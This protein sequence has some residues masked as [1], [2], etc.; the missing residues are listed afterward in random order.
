MELMGAV[1]AFLS[2]DDGRLL[3]ADYAKRYCPKPL[4]FFTSFSSPMG[5]QEQDA[6]LPA[7]RDKPLLGRRSVMA[8]LFFKSKYHG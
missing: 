6:T 4:S 5:Q 7:Q 2:A 8:G 1:V 3:L